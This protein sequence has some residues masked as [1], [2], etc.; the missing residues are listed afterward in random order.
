M[1]LFIIRINNF[2]GNVT[3]TVLRQNQKRWVRSSG[4]ISYSMIANLGTLLCVFV[5]HQQFRVH[6]CLSQGTQH[7]MLAPLWP[8]PCKVSEQ[9]SPQSSGWAAIRSHTINQCSYLTYIM[10]GC[11]YLHPTF[12]MVMQSC[13]YCP[14]WLD[15]YRELKLRHIKF[16]PCA[17]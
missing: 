4:P 15:R 2:L 12:N 3:C 11:Y 17:L 16:K 6:P 8:A 10:P 7:N 1:L 14:G 13:K 9:I 5:V